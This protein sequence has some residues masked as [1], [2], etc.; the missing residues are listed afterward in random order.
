MRKNKAS[1]YKTRILFKSRKYCTSQ[2]PCLPCDAS[3]LLWTLWR[4]CISQ[5]NCESPINKWTATVY[6]EIS[7]EAIWTLNFTAV[8]EN[9]WVSFC[10]TFKRTQ[11]ALYI[12]PKR[13]F[14]AC[15]WNYDCP[16]DFHK[17]LSVSLSLLTGVAE[18][19]RNG[20][21]SHSAF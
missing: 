13:A 16:S 15:S 5:V 8:L 4:A 21:I 19:S 2:L 20:R 17:C 14:Q 7:A 18:S 10:K 12:C 3:T 6:K 11:W 9:W 1:P